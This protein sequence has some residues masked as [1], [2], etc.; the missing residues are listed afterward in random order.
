MAFKDKFGKY[1]AAYTTPTGST[2]VINVFSTKAD[3]ERE[4]RAAKNSS[5]FRQLGYKNPRVRLNK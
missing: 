4:V 2:A 5:A 3:A 1:V